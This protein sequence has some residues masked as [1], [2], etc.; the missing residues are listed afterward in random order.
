MGRIMVSRIP[1]KSPHYETRSQLRPSGPLI[2]HFNNVCSNE[3]THFYY[4]I[5]PYIGLIKYFIYT[6][7]AN[8]KTNTHN[9]NCNR[10]FV[11]T[12]SQL[13]QTSVKNSVVCGIYK[14]RGHSLG[15]NWRVQ[16]V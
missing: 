4:L 14:L 1:M 5:S 11:F 3:N 13:C 2:N 7:L 15:V 8:I 10:P 16:C 12:A 9:T 6:I